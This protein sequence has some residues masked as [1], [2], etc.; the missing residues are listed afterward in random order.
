LRHLDQPAIPLH[1]PG[2]KG[3]LGL[4]PALAPWLADAARLDLTE[5]DGLDSLHAPTGPIAAA[6]A[7]AAQ[8]WKADRTYFL[9]G[10]S[11]VGV[12]AMIL[13]ACNPGDTVILP[14]DAHMSALGGLILAGAAPAYVSLVPTGHGT[15]GPPDLATLSEAIAAH[16]PKAVLLTRPSYAG[17]VFDLESYAACIHAAGAVLLVDEAHGAH[18]GLHTALPPSALSQGADAVVQSTHKMLGALTPGAMLHLKGLR[19]RESRVK[20]ALSLL[21]TTSPSYLV[22]ASL[23]AARRHEATAAADRWERPLH[24]AS[25]ARTRLA[26]LPG[27]RVLPPGDPLKI[28][29]DVAGLGLDG[30]AAADQLAERGVIIEHATHRHVVAFMGPGTREEDLLGLV[31]AFQAMA[32]DVHPCLGPSAEPAMPPLPPRVLL[33]REAYFAESRPVAWESS[34]GQ[35]AAE[36]VCP[37]PP[38]APALVPG[39]RITEEVVEYVD[40]LRAL[41]AQMAGPEDPNLSTIRI[42]A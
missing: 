37:Y 20:S 38:G 34:V 25:Q 7:L 17:D 28:G 12:Q 22:L 36:L 8:L 5:L 42:V 40:G 39:E 19:L 32:T 14:R 35:V 15:W 2:H 9:V 33:P 24:W 11:T 18:L 3:G 21:Q 4:D 27:L 6:Q 41:G 13:A 31:E 26:E 29:V 10:G 30:Y 16:R 1:V 23:D